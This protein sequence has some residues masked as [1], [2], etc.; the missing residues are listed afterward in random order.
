M[1]DT[2]QLSELNGG[3]ADQDRRLRSRAETRSIPHAS[4]E[5]TTIHCPRLLH[6]IEII[7][8]QCSRQSQR[9]ESRM[10]EAHVPPRQYLSDGQ[11]TPMH[12]FDTQVPLTHAWVPVQRSGNVVQSSGRHSPVG[13]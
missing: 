1:H 2:D 7:T 8:R 6:D 10:D 13:R 12:G 4:H 9:Q 5:V 3:E 11:V